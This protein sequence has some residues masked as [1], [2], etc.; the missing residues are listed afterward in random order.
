MKKTT[1]YLIRHGESIGNATKTMLGH[2]NLD[3]SEH[4]YKQAAATAEH[5]RDTSFDA[6]YSSDL[7]RAYN[8][9]LPHAQMRGLEVICDKGLRELSVGDWEGKCVTE[10]LDK[11]Y[12]EFVNQWHGGF[13]TFKFPGGEGVMDGGHRFH[14]TVMRIAK[15]N[16]GKTLIVAA[17]AAVIRAFWSIISGISPEDI[18]EKLPFPSNAS[19]SICE[20]DGERLIPLEYS[21]DKHLESVGITHVITSQDDKILRSKG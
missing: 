11:W 21:C 2:T 20:L 8:T 4:G 16:L 15:Q 18:V 3:L 9:A 14:D 17:H 19:Y 5:L 1:I 6:I 7:M 10:I 12:D 13:G